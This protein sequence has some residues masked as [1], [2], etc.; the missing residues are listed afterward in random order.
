MKKLT[1]ICIAILFIASFLL[2]SSVLAGDAESEDSWYPSRY[3]KDD[4]LGALNLV[5]SKK[6]RDALKLIKEARQY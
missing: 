2:S 4:T 5:D 3:G 1:L 6:S